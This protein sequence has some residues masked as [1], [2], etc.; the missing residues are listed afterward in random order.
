[1]PLVN[2]KYIEF[3]STYRDRSQYPN[4]AD[5]NVLSDQTEYSSKNASDPVSQAAMIYPRPYQVSPITFENYVYIFQPQLPLAPTA[6]M[7]GIIPS[8]INE[9]GIFNPN[10][11]TDITTNNQ[12]NLLNVCK[13]F[14]GCLL[15]VIDDT[16]GGVTNTLHRYSTILKSYLKSVTIVSGTIGNVVAAP[17]INSFELV[18]ATPNNIT[19][20]YV[21]MKIVINPGTST[22]VSRTISYYRGTDGRV[23]FDD[24]ILPAPTPATVVAIVYD[25]CVIL[26]LTTPLDVIPVASNAVDVSNF[27][28]ARIRQQYEPVEQGTLSATTTTTFT[29]PASATQLDYTGMFIWLTSRPIVYSGTTAVIITGNEFNFTAATTFPD[30]YFMNYYIVSEDFEGPYY[31]TSFDGSTQT[32]KIYG[33]WTGD[34]TIVPGNGSNFIIYSY[35]PATQY[36]KITTYNTTTRVGTIERSFSYPNHLGQKVI[37][38]PNNTYTYDILNINQDYANSFNYIGSRVSQNQPTCYNVKLA[39]LILPNEPILSSH[40]GTILNYP[41]VYVQFIPNSGITQHPIFSNNPNSVQCL[42]KVPIVNFYDPYTRFIDLVSTDMI[43]LVKIK[44]TDNFT[45]RILLPNGE[46]FRTRADTISPM[47]PDTH[48]QISAIFELSD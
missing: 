12:V 2:N 6:S 36:R 48:I 19:N 47:V 37:F 34:P 25:K 17:D 15:E 39:H 42:F 31:I 24:P 44:P 22:E 46:I 43:P 40:G 21:G 33:T 8:F 35:Y 14:S 16:L 23:F 5:F 18:S 20:F 29:L 1:M 11:S 10:L 9:N 13:I 32:G 41:Y 27:T 38:T 45:F 26:E 4:P 28:T 7:V 30:N 3:D